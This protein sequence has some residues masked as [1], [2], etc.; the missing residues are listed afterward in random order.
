M[1]ERENNILQESL[2]I[3]KTHFISREMIFGGHFTVP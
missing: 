3:L 2:Q 1:E